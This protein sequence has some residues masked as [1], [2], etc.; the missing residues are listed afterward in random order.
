MVAEHDEDSGTLPDGIDFERPCVARVYDYLLGGSHNFAVDR[1]AADRYLAR[2]PEI[3][4][5]VRANRSFLRRAVRHATDAGVR[6]F[7][8]LGSGL[9]TAGNVHEAAP[10]ARVVYV[11]SEPAAVAHGRTMLAGASDRVAML[12]ADLRD[13][14]AVLGAPQVRELL[15]LDRPVGVLLVGVLHFVPAGEDLAGLVG[16]Y[17][18]AM[19]P[20][21]HLVV[22]AATEDGDGF[23]WAS[24]QSLHAGFHTLARSEVTRLFD[25]F[26]LVDPG[27]V[28]ATRW[29][30]DSAQPSDEL[31]AKL[32]GV[33]GVGRL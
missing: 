4:A 20:G 33:V 23:D 31:V 3:A 10:E 1:A 27:L 32:P 14:D 26:E 2:V 22:S 13:V 12:H 30:P 9:P 8:D 24:R 19:A 15:D 21:S 5:A 18:V 16:K 6:Q 17:R 25:G 29:R 28:H 11:D 7:L